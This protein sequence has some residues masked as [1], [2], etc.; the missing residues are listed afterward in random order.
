[1]AGD[2][3]ARASDAEREGA[4]G[5]DADA[6]TGVRPGA[7]AGDDRAEVVRHDAGARQRRLD[8]GADHLGV[9]ARVGLGALGEHA[10]VAVD[11]G[12]GRPRGGVDGQ[13]HGSIVGDAS[14]TTRASSAEP[15]PP[16]G[17]PSGARAW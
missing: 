1:V 16:R 17:G 14:D 2:R 8:E 10:A 3:E 11:E 5:D 12:D 9:T 13:D 6:Q 15:A 7:D 4:R